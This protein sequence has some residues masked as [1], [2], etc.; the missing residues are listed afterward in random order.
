MAKKATQKFLT[1]GIILLILLGFFGLPHMVMPTDASGGMTMT[2][3]PLMF[4][5]AALCRMDLLG[6]I[7]G[8]Q[9]MLTGIVQQGDI[10]LLLSLLAAL[11]A[12][13]LWQKMRL[14]EIENMRMAAKAVRGN[15][16]LPP[17]PLLELFSRGV[18]NPKPY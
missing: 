15:H 11:I 13:R 7:A 3:C 16:L 2:N 1:S 12:V 17:S 8:W 4:G 9:S 6:H 18:L 14:P 5:Q 10:A